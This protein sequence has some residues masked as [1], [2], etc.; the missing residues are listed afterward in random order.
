MSET[1]RAAAVPN[2]QRIYAV[3]DIH[4]RA[5]LLIALME[6]IKKDTASCVGV[7]KCVVFLGDYVDRGSQSKQVIDY[8]IHKIPPE[9]KAV[10]LRGNH[11]EAMLLFLSGDTDAGRGWLQFGGEETLVS[12]NVNP[13]HPRSSADLTTARLSLIE[14]L[15]A[16]HRDF[17]ISTQLSFTVG[18]YHFVHAGIKPGIPLDEQTSDDML[19]IRN[20]FLS[21]RADHGKI[22][23]HGHSIRS[24]PDIQPNRIGIDTGAYSSNHLTC[25]ILQNT[26]RHIIST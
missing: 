9:L 19:W 3:G 14:K 13:S 18:D 11:E 21:S 26:Q 15:P 16:L 4:G 22:I 23:V 10:F 24:K 17:L 12:Y 20:E 25:L 2:N 8:L 6:L 1:G 5:D 7:N